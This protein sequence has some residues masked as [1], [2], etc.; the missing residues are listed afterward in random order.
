LFA[1]ATLA[2][3]FIRNMLL[4][5]L[6]LVLGGFA[7]I[8]VMSSLNVSAQSA[9]PNWV[10]ARALGVYLLVF[11]GGMALGSFAWGSVA[12]LWGNSTALAA[13]AILLSLSSLAVVRWRLHGVQSLD[14][15]PASHWQEPEMAITPAPEDGPVLVTIE[16]HIAVERAHAFVNAM[17]R[18]GRMRR[19]TGAYQWGLFEDPASPG[20][21][22]ETFHARTWAEH[23]RQHTRATVT[24]Q[25]IEDRAL[26]F[27]EPGSAPVVTHLI[28]AHPTGKDA[29]I[30]TAP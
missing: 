29:P 30:G 3:G 2:P 20:R 12:D 26:S 9:A 14:L 13:G 1:L 5:V 23:M 18:V 4:L 7:W 16:Y 6:L 25:R 8:A 15:S 24:D 10:R 22:V 19:R 28:A 27:Q 17:Q 21:F 11:Q